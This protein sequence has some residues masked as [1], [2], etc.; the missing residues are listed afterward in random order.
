[1]Q[2]VLLV[3]VLGAQPLPPRLCGEDLHNVLVI[4]AVDGKGMY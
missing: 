4:K 1:M 2:S 3:K